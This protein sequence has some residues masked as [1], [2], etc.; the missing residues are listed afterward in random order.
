MSIK[1]SEFKSKNFVQQCH[2]NELVRK[3]KMNPFVDENNRLKKSLIEEERSR[4]KCSNDLS[5][6][7]IKFKDAIKPKACPSCLYRDQK[8]FSSTGVQADAGDVEIIGKLKKQLELGNMELLQLQEKYKTLQMIHKKNCD[9]FQLMEKE[10]T[11]ENTVNNSNT[12]PRNDAEIIA[13]Q[14][15]YTEIFEKYNKLKGIYN[16]MKA[17]YEE[18]KPTICQSVQTDPIESDLVSIIRFLNFY[19]VFFLLFFFC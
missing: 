3:N 5:E 18:Q 16:V 6:L 9:D 4:I 1:L 12:V 13:L 11:K 8:T 15:Q 14:K 2:I 10:R 7:K 19:E 17:K